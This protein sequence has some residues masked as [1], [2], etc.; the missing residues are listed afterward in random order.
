MNE[1]IDIESWTDSLVGKALDVF[2]PR[3]K[4]VGIQGSRARGEARSDSDIDVVLIVEG[5]DDDDLAAYRALLATMPHGDLACGFTGSPELLAAWPRHD[6]FNLVQ[7]TRAV[8][9]SFDFMDTEF[10]ADD[11]MLSAKVGASEIYHAMSHELV[12][13]E[14]SLDAI[15]AVCVKSAFFVMR[16]L[17]YAKTGEY[18]PSRAAMRELATEQEAMFLDA[19]DNPDAFGTE[20]LAHALLAWSSSIV[21]L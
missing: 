7:D 21:S 18:P 12:F 14:G 1:E 19:Y 6:V 2:G 15:V 13:A 16:A 8:F 4:L 17:H 11:A 20:E 10:T 5:L 9:G 3:L